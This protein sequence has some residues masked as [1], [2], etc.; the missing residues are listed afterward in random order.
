MKLVTAVIRPFKLEEVKDAL[1]AIGIAGITTAEVRGFGRQG[2]HTESYRG[3][4]YKV[5]LV[6]KVQV[7]VVVDAE[8]VDG[9]VDAIVKAGATGKIGDG[10]IW[11]TDV[12]RVIR[13]RTGEEGLDAI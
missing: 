9:V 4:E 12:D 6:P 2:G 7:D 13:I 5:E 10:K 1:K 11:V 8:G 3:T